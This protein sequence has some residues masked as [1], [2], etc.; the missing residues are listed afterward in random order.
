MEST[1]IDYMTVKHDLYIRDLTFLCKNA[2]CNAAVGYRNAL[3]GAAITSYVTLVI[4]ISIFVGLYASIP[5]LT[6]IQRM[7]HCS[8]ISAPKNTPSVMACS[9]LFISSPHFSSLLPILSGIPPLPSPAFFDL[10]QCHF[11]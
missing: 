1:H 2:P 5:P 9:G 4:G 8:S 10:F 7:L 11:I 3:G 6:T